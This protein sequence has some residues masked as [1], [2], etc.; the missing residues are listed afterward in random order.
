MSAT[1]GLAAA[2]VDLADERNGWDR[3]GVSNNLNIASLAFGLASLATGIGSAPAAGVVA[4]RTAKA[5]QGPLLG[6]LFPKPWGVGV[7]ITSFVG[8]DGRVVTSLIG[9]ANF[10]MGL[11]ATVAGGRTLNDYIDWRSSDAGGG[12]S[13]GGET[14]LNSPSSPWNPDR[15]P[16]ASAAPPII[17]LIGSLHASVADYSHLTSRIRQSVNS[18]LYSSI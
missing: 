13:G 4:A 1:L 6:Q 16:N 11:Y 18:E 10:G 2:G 14:P 7:A 3:R 5:G 9:V 15:E 17:D 12:G 8:I